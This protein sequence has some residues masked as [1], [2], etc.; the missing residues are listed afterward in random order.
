MRSVYLHYDIYS[1]IAYEQ[2]KFTQISTSK[3]STPEIS[4][5][6]NASVMFHD[7]INFSGWNLFVDS[8]VDFRKGLQTG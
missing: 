3:L 4:E 2:L 6:L 8:F 1:R 7:A 5:K